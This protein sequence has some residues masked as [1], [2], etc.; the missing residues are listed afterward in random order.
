MVS[1]QR[2]WYVRPA[3]RET[4]DPKMDRR[5]PA[6]SEAPKPSGPVWSL[7][8]SIPRPRAEA[9]IA[10][11]KRPPELV[12]SKSACTGPTPAGSGP[13]GKAAERC[14]ARNRRIV[15]DAELVI[16]FVAPDRTEDTILRAVRAGKAIE[17]ALSAS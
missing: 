13:D 7:R 1:E 11:R 5:W 6:I 15:D 14:Y 2:F 16:A 3:R 17:V 12:G 10:G 4:R 8:A 9:R